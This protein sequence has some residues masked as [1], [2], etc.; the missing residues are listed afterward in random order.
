ML[1]VDG[2]FI[3]GIIGMLKLCI[4]FWFNF[5]TS[6]ACRHLFLL[7]ICTYVHVVKIYPYNY[8]NFGVAC[9]NVSFLH[10]ILLIWFSIIYSA[11]GVQSLF[12]K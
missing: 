3:T 9:C 8:L 6:N 5:G 1:L 12:F 11:K 7:Y 4:S 2:K 10:I